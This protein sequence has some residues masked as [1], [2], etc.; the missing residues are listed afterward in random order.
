MIQSIYNCS[1]QIYW[2]LPFL[3]QVTRNAS[4]ELQGR[5]L[6][7]KLNKIFFFW[8][9]TV[10]MHIFAFCIY[11]FDCKPFQVCWITKVYSYRKINGRKWAHCW[12]EHDEQLTLYKAINPASSFG[13]CFRV[14]AH[15]YD[16]E[17]SIPISLHTINY[18]CIQVFQL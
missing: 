9:W 17:R 13:D 18:T 16:Y 11:K 3:P 6:Q 14:V 15:I 2:T 10:S 8:K 12:Y 7:R 5:L 1:S 4:L